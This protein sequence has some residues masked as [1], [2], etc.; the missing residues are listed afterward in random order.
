MISETVTIQNSKGLHL[1]PVTVLSEAACRYRSHCF[2]RFNGREADL[3]SVLSLLAA[4]LRCGDIA[5]V[6]CEGEDEREAMEG[7]LDVF[8]NGFGGQNPA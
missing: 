5:E 6:V 2:I 7:I 8:R 3:K 4:G 1:R